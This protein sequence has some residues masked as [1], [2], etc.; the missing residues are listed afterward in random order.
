MGGGEYLHYTGK[1]AFNASLCAIQA[2]EVRL[3]LFNVWGSHVGTLSASEIRDLKDGATYE[4]EYSWQLWSLTEGHEHHASI[5]YIARVRTA[6][7]R[8]LDADSAFILREAQRFTE[9]FTEADLEP[10]APQK[11]T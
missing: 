9:K 7:G 8:V 4:Q 1:F 10:K 6:D 3:L 11:G 2:F 5:A